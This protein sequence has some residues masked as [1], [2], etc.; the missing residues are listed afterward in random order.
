MGLSGLGDSRRALAS[1]IVLHTA[2]K[3]HPAFVPNKRA[4]TLLTKVLN[5]TPT[6]ETSIEAKIH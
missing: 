2:V 3:L 4:L 6:K 5:T 1:K